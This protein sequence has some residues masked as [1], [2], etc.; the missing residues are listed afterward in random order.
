ML[1]PSLQ[2]GFGELSISE[3]SQLD[4]YLIEAARQ[5]FS[6]E[7]ES[8]EATTCSDWQQGQ[9]WFETRQ[10]LM[11]LWVLPRDM[12]N[13]SW[14]NYKLAANRGE[15]GILQLVPQLL[16]LKTHRCN[17]IGQDRIE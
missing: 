3:P 16:R 8:V 14:E 1:V 7:C 11:K 4:E 13:G 5:S 12:S 10:S 17:S 15:Q 6:W 9:Y 2:A